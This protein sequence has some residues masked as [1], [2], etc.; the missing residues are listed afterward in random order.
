MDGLISGP[1]ELSLDWDGIWDVATRRGPSGWTAEIVVPAQT[2]AFRKGESRWGFNVERFVPRDR[3][4]L[5]WSGTTLDSLIDDVSRAGALEGVGALEQGLG[6]SVSPYALAR[7]RSNRD[8]D[9]RTFGGTSGGDVSYNLTPQLAG[10]LTVNTDF[11]E[12]EVDTRQVNLTRFSLFFPEKRAF[13]VEG[14]NLFQFGLGLD[15][16]FIPFY[17]RRIGLFEG[18]LA[19][20]DAGVK[21]L[22]YAGR[23]GLALLDVETG[24]GAGAPGTNLFAG[25]VTYDADSHLRLGA[26]GTS[27]NPDGV[28][29][30][31]LGGIDA[32]WRTSTFAGDKNF[33]VG[34]WGARRAVAT[35]LRA[36]GPAG[37]SRSPIPTTCGTFPSVTTTSATRSTR[38]SDFSRAPAR[39]STR[40]AA[41]IS[42]AR[43]EAPSVGSDSSSLSSSGLS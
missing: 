6:L 27:G 3:T 16:L 21:V 35:G 25:R 37:A 29:E 17:S 8:S 30:N 1:G 26:A 15:D 36:A 28:H 11:A 19:P 38:G 31:S 24:D 22:G 9:H 34:A 42:R 43:R 12:T 7:F 20:I 41:P 5:R 14:A 23:F 10:V 33:S 18:R 2:L 13:F 39:V 32:V 4:T 40:P